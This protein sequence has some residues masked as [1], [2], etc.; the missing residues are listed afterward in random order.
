MTSPMPRIQ[1]ADGISNG[2]HQPDYATILR[3]G[4]KQL[5]THWAMQNAGLQKQ[6]SGC[7][8]RHPELMQLSKKP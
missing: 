8:Q 1:P 5:Q 7:T 4:R 2:H 6:N 3:E